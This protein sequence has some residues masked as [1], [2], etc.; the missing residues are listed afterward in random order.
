MKYL[1][2]SFTGLGNFIQRTPFI[3]CIHKY[4]SKAVIDLIG[5]N[6]YGTFDIIKNSEEI[7]KIFLVPK[8][9][10]LR[11]KLSVFFKLKKN[12]YDVIFL[13]F[14]PTPNWFRRITRFINCKIIVEHVHV[15]D[16]RN[17]N[18]KKFLLYSLN[19]K[20]KLVPILPGRH[21]IDL[22]YDLLESYL[23]IPIQRK[24]N[25]WL[26]V[27]Y[28]Y[29]I[30]DKFGLVPQKYFC[31]QPSAAN[32]MPAP[33]VWDPGNFY[34]L[35]SI[36]QKEYPQLKNVL[37]GDEGDLKNLIQKHKWPSGT[38]CTAGKTTINEVINLLLYA[39]CVIA[40]DSAIMHLANAVN[41]PL[42][43]LYG[44]TDYRRTAPKGR[45]TK[46]LFSKTEAFAAM[47]NWKISERELVAKYPNYEAMNGISVND[48][49]QAVKWMLRNK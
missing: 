34:K 22:Y 38:I 46:I 9:I 37:V 33:K 11:N 47:Y 32:G 29:S 42:I 25:T 3:S 44:P 14:D 1:I 39:S 16:L 36:L 31:I 18:F 10:R 2:S 20:I 27:E 15:D 13:P 17:I 23:N 49:L 6:R 28:D 48:V 43:A 12:K 4:D 19:H 45:N 26:S 5:D 30:L 7:R 21:E 8:N 35:I 40:H 41:V 24:Y